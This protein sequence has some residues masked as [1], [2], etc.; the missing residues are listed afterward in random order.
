MTPG[1]T[2]ADRT[3]ALARAVEIG[4]GRYR[5]DIVDA[6]EAV[7][8]KARERL[9]H[10]SRHTVVALVGPTGSGKSSLFNALAGEDISTTGVLRPTTTDTHAVV[11]AD[12]A[13]SLLDWLEIGRR[14]HA[15]ADPELDGLVL[16]DLPDFDSTE[17][18]NRIEVDRL[19]EL[20]DLLIWVVE[21]Q[22]YADQSLHAGY[23]RPLAG[24]GDV[25]A[26]VLSKTDTL[27]AEERDDAVADFV[28]LLQADGIINPPVLQASVLNGEGVEDILSVVT[29]A[30][31][32][33]QAMVQRLAADIRR[34]A[35][36]LGH[37]LG[38]AEEEPGVTPAAHDALNAGLG[39]AAGVEEAGRVV[40]AQY[41]RDA[42]LVTGWPPT[43]WLSRLRRSP[44]GDL[45]MPGRSTVARAEVGTAL[46]DVGDAVAE[47]LPRPWDGSIRRLALGQAETVR[48]SLARVNTRTMRHQR[49]GP[50]W[51]S[52]VD[53]LQRVVGMVALAGAAWLTVLAV[54]GGL[55]QL[56]TEAM[57]P[58]VGDWMP[59]PTLLLLAG[60]LAGVVIMW[61]ARL[62]ASVGGSRRAVRATAMWRDEVTR[63]ADEDVVAPIQAALA[64]RRELADLLAVA[65]GQA[66]MNEAR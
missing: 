5:E 23:L 47:G 33:R 59:L 48:G 26:F 8:T 44:I 64:E 55:L 6:A 56:D 27:S 50:R 66:A 24:H 37:G 43:R 12:D 7:V 25:M 16:L 19:V 46:R 18:A 1:L 42:G 29:A 10:G 14:H 3:D 11:W 20:V 4:R 17:F 22:K 40:A 57:T 34:T 58:T 62:A 51:W 39:R 49:A 52:A 63:V 31:R 54:V 2:L 45:P 13:S 28:N 41:R 30:A 32:E 21:P 9:R 60:A 36:S 53:W 35:I 65:A 38:P 15:A 61:L